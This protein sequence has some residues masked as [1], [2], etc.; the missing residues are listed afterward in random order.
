[1]YSVFINT[2]DGRLTL[3]KLE[4]WDLDENQKFYIINCTEESLTL[5]RSMVA[6]SLFSSLGS[7]QRKSALSRTSCLCTFVSWSRLFSRK[8]I[9]CF[10]ASEPPSSSL[11]SAFTDCT[12][13]LWNTT[14]TC[15]TRKQL[16][17]YALVVGRYWNPT[18]HVPKCQYWLAVLVPDGT[19][20][21][22][23]CARNGFK[24]LLSSYDCY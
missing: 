14:A 2:F 13:K 22:I 6:L 9:F 4:I 3:W 1:M 8:L 11:S 21:I 5:T 19:K 10:C 17:A 7:S 20:T 15:Q 24:W 23:S 12:N 18:V 16:S